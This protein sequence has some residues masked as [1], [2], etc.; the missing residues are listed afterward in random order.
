MGRL[1]RPIRRPDWNR[2]DRRRPFNR[3]WPGW[4]GC[5]LALMPFPHLAGGPTWV[6]PWHQVDGTL[7]N[8][9]PA[10]DWVGTEYGASL[11]TDGVAGHVYV[12]NVPSSIDYVGAGLGSIAISFWWLQN[13][14]DAYIC[15]SNSG[16]PNVE[17]RVIDSTGMLQLNA[18]NRWGSWGFR[19][20]TTIVPNTR[21]IM[22]WN[23]A[24]LITINGTSYSN[25]VY[26]GGGWGN[27]YIGRNGALYGNAIVDWLHIYRDR[28][29]SVA[30]AGRL[31]DESLTAWPDALRWLR[32][33]SMVSVP[34]SPVVGSR[35]LNLQRRSAAA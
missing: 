35:L 21:Y 12:P 9:D 24:G 15:T 16:F 3:D 17:I 31:V 18:S 14:A 4:D 20:V 28:N 29:M 22:T 13:G 34:A 33:R 1:A 23:N 7:T 26:A 5:Q 30:E 2:L 6:D 32:G 19:D 25:G 10:S 27:I 8:M 11:R